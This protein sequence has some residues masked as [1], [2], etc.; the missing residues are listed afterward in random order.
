MEITTPK[1]SS[2]FPVNVCMFRSYKLFGTVIAYA[3]D[4]NFKAITVIS[5]RKGR[6]IMV[7][8]GFAGT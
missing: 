6:R 8:L 7:D 4:Y 2:F 5:I 3:V 1:S